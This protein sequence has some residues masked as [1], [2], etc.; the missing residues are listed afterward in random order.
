M[1]EVA[2][3]PTIY[4]SKGLTRTINNQHWFGY[5]AIGRICYLSR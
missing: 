5:L 1:T 4:A 3:F 2:F